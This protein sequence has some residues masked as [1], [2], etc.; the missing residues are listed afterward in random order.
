MRHLPDRL[1]PRRVCRRL[2]KGDLAAFRTLQ[3][4]ALPAAARLSDAELTDALALGELWGIFRAGQ[5]LAALTL[6]PMDA[7]CRPCLAPARLAEEGLCAL[8]DPAR[9]ALVW[10]PAADPDLCM[11]DAE[12]AMSALLETASLRAE[13]LGLPEGIAAAV[14]VRGA[15]LE[16]LFRAGLWM[17]G[18]R[19]LLRLCACYLFTL[20][21]PEE[22]LYN[23]EHQ[24]HLPLGETR[25]LGRRLEEG[26]CAA[27]CAG[28]ELVLT[29][30]T[31]ERPAG[32]APGRREGTR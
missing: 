20:A 5:L 25:L 2:L 4:R 17:T 27:G 6:L 28:T 22:I 3:S 19:P 8:P 29:R 15:A 18:L 1:P 9:T 23:K 16:G 26:W 10:A 32:P 7:P 24:L 12:A 13:T 30:R 21:P 31:A 14:P 11:G